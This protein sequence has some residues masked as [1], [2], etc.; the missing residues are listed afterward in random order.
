MYRMI[1]CVS[2]DLDGTLVKSNFADMFWLEGLP[3]IYAEEKG[4]DIEKA[5]AFL[6]EDYQSI[7][8]D[9]IE[10]Y[11]PSFWF[12]RYGL[13]YS[14]KKLIDDYKF[15]IE[16]YP[17][18][19]PT[20]KKLKGR[21][22]LII[23][24]NAKKEFVETELNETGFIK[25]FSHIFSSVSDFGMVKK[26]PKVYEKVCSML[27]LEKDEIVHVGDDKIFDYEVPRSAGIKAI[28]LDRKSRNKNDCTVNSLADL[29]SLLSKF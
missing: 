9:R 5:R 26:S 17:D 14:W 16:P 1:K 19:L 12:R 2:F 22:K 27:D 4:I 29:P 11:D 23:L 7:G 21:Y 13:N 18:A 15:A 10:W 24:S 8:K 6:I 25:Y 28:L 3:R 20:L